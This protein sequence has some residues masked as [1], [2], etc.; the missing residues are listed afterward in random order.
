[1]LSCTKCGASK[2]DDDFDRAPK[3]RNRR[4]R[5][6][7]CRECSRAAAR[8]YKRRHPQKTDPEYAKAYWRRKRAAAID[9]LGG[10]CV[11][12]GFSDRRA[13]QFDH[14]DGS[15]FQ[16]RKNNGFQAYPSIRRILAGDDG[17]Q[18]LCANCNWIKRVE[19][20]E[21]LAGSLRGPAA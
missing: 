13:L 2:P 10:V 11:R 12:C 15:G 16:Q 6:S 3:N 1:M 20:N 19:N 14:T 18:L 21:H 9:L 4:G 8:D 5:A 17:F 7:W